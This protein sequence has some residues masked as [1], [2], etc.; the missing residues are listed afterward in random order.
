[1]TRTLD[2]SVPLKHPYGVSWVPLQ[3]P[4]QPEMAGRMYC[5]NCN[6]FHEAVLVDVERFPEEDRDS[7]VFAFPKGTKSV[8]YAPC[9]GG[10]WTAS[11]TAIILLPRVP[12]GVKEWRP[13][14]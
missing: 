5:P 3:F 11:G 4:N 13:S 8:L 7:L 10:V 9:C 1:M 6:P 2:E 12:P 14:K